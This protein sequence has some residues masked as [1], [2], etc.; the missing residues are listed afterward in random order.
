MELH[1]PPWVSA[2]EANQIS[3]RLD[4]WAQDLLK[5]RHLPSAE[6]CA[7]GKAVQGKCLHACLLHM[8]RVKSLVSAG[9]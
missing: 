4:G 6:V 1:V 9:A 8:C 3:M 2:N 5:V 7:P